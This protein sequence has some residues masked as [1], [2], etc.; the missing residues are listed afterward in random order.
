MTNPN[1]SGPISIVGLG[2]VGSR[3]AEGL[4]RL[5][6][7]THFSPL[8]FYDH[9]QFEAHNIRNQL[10]TP[11]HVG[12]DKVTAVGDQLLAINKKLYIEGFSVEVN[13]KIVLD[14][15]IVF[16]CLDTMSARREIIEHSIGPNVRCVIETRMDSA[17]GMSHCFN[18]HLKKHLECWWLYWHD[19]DET[20]NKAGCQGE[21]PVISAIFGTTCL[22]LKQFEAYLEGDGSALGIN[23]R[24]Y[25]DFDAGL[26]KCETWPT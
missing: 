8:S 16:L 5:G 24:I 19:D 23:N 3:V 13:R 2:G 26:T 4:V 6:C 15:P 17:A 11:H 7:G 10:V 9:D 20:E 1:V 22:A 25:T 14:S 18:P 12:N 21:S